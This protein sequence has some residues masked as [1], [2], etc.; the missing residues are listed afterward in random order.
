MA[1]VFSERTWLRGSMSCSRLPKA[2]LA[3]GSVWR[4]ILL[5]QPVFTLISISSPLLD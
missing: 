5:S 4:G 3:F 1:C 2:L